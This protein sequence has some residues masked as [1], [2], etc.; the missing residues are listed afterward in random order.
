MIR[1]IL[2]VYLSILNKAVHKLDDLDPNVNIEIFVVY[3]TAYLLM[4]FRN[5][6]LAD[7]EEI[8]FYVGLQVDLVD[9]PQAILDRMKGLFFTTNFE[10]IP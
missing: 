3:F 4:T 1:H 8:Q 10:L 5:R 2:P 6:S 7:D 9:Q